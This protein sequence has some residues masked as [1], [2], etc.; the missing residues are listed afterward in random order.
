VRPENS[1]ER[2]FYKKKKFTVG[3]SRLDDR[4]NATKSFEQS[5]ERTVPV[6]VGVVGVSS[7]WCCS[8]WS[9]RWS[10]P[11]PRARIGP[12]NDRQR[13]CKRGRSPPARDG[14][15]PHERRR[16]Y[17]RYPGRI[18]WANEGFT[19]MTGYALAEVRGR[20]R[21]LFSKGR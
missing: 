14:R 10:E 11:D 12:G 19:R 15:E 21:A 13:S 4:F 6:L 16:G 9:F 2:M 17:Q 20:S 8:V 7:R 18:E 3:G 1:G 5:I